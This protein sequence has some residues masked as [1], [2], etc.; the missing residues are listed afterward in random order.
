MYDI[1]TKKP[2]GN[3]RLQKIS[4]ICKS[5][6]YRVNKSVFECQISEQ[7]FKILINNIKN[8]IDKDDSLRIYHNKK[9]KIFGKD[10]SVNFDEDI[11][12]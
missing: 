7:Q 5:C 8:N 6:G 9:I 4:K 1:N 12:I 11:I 2:N 3:K 10:N